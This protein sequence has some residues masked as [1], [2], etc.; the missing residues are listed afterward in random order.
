MAFIDGA[1]FFFCQ[2]RH[3]RVNERERRSGGKGRDWT[4]LGSNSHSFKSVEGVQI[5]TELKT[6]LKIK[7]FPKNPRTDF[8]SPHKKLKRFQQTQKQQRLLFEL[9]YFIIIHTKQGQH[10][11]QNKNNSKHHHHGFY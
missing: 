5:Q 6:E 11:H 7:I 9:V 8:S 4:Q 10:Q 3:F 2:D 1:V